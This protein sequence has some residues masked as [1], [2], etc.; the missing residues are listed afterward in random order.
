M[1]N[2]KSRKT[3]IAVLTGAISG[4]LVALA[5][6]CPELMPW[7]DA[8]TANTIAGYVVALGV[9]LVLGVAHEDNG[10]NAGAARPL[11]EKE[12]TGL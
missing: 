12:K 8:E 6:S 5:K 11:T 10:R 2:L 9:S 7:L 4:G 3:W 1:P